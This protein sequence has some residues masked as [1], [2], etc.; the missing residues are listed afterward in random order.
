MK[1][2]LKVLSAAMLSAV[3]AV[4]ASA[5]V[6]AATGINAAEQKVL[7]EL[8][9]TVTMNGA[10]KSLPVRYVNQAEQY[11]AN[12]C[13]M[14]DAQAT[15]VITK[16]KA[17]KDYLEGTGKSNW[18][19]LTDAEVEKAVS[20]A[21]EAAAVVNCT[22]EYNKSSK[23]VSVVTKG[24]TGTS[25]STTSSK[26]GTSSTST[27]QTVVSGSTTGKDAIKTTG[28]GVPGVTAVAGVGFLV[29]TAAGV[30]LIST[31]KKKETIGA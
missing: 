28:F 5:S 23:T 10:E 1:K 8:N 18:N 12:D 16:I 14:T 24:S 7:D 6:F 11:F 26:P 2:V 19:S 31:S 9:T 29:V 21:K 27:S 20:L 3:V 4:G 15:E 13:D 17:V 25:G 22:I 30:Y